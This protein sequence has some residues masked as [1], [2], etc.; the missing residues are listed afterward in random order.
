MAVEIQ[1][2]IPQY[3]ELNRIYSDF[4]ISHTISL[5]S[6]NSLRTSISN[7]M[8]QQPLKPLSLNW[9]LTNIKNNIL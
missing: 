7:T 2:M 9:C 3:G 5:T 1:I 8:I 4:I 6:R